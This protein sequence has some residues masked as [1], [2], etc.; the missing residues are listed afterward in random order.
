[1]ALAPVGTAVAGPLAAAYGTAT[2]LNVGGVII[3]AITIP[4]LFVP[5]VRHLSR[6]QLEPV[7]EPAAGQASTME[8]PA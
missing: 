6:R 5:E 3:V 4:V 7:P 8:R 1:M 2:V